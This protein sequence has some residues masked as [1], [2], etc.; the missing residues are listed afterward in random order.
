MNTWRGHTENWLALVRHA[1]P[2]EGSLSKLGVP[3]FMADVKGDLTGISQAGTLGDKLGK[4][5]AQRKLPTPAPQ[6]WSMRLTVALAA[7]AANRAAARVRRSTTGLGFMV[8]PSAVLLSCWFTP[9]CGAKGLKPPPDP[10]QMKGFR[11]AQAQPG[12]G[13]PHGVDAR[14]PAWQYAGP[15]PA[16]PK[17]AA[18]TRRVR[19]RE[20]PPGAR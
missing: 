1:C 15:G 4:I 11:S 10:L 5:I 13:R 19:A 16:G 7:C 8:R 6:V 12:G 2:V 20:R 3:V 17:P 14:A 9:A 18:P